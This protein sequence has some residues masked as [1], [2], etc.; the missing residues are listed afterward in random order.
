[1]DKFTELRQGPER[2]VCGVVILGAT[3]P[4][5][6]STAEIISGAGARGQQLATPAPPEQG[7]RRNRFRDNQSYDPRCIG[8]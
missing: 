2:E 7:A 8:L 1:M 6:K 3:G 5:G 4:I